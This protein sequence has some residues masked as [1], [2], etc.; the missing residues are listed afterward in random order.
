MKCILKKIF[1]FLTI[2]AFAFCLTACN[3]EELMENLQQG[4]P[5]IGG[6]NIEQTPDPEPEPTPETPTPVLPT[7]EDRVGLAIKKE[8]E[9][10]IS[11][12]TTHHTLWTITG[13]IV[14]MD[15][16]YFNEQYQNYNVKMIIEVD[17]VLI[18]IYNGQVNGKFPDNIDG[19]AVGVMVTATGTIAENYI[20][21]SGKYTTPIQLGR[22]EISWDAN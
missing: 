22:P 19:L 12:E 5:N 18:G 17:G 11:G 1:T 13:V 21:T 7:D 16:T 4:I 6:G 2:F 10:L 9:A 3:M 20:I 15:A 14:D 8:Y